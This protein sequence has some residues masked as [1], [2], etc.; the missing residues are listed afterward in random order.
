MRYRVLEPRRAPPLALVPP[1]EREPESGVVD[2]AMSD[3]SLVVATRAGDRVARETLFR[4]HAPAAFGLA[5]RLL[6]RADGEVDDLVQESLL[7]CVRGLDRLETPAAFGSW[8]S[9]I[10]V[11]TACKVIRRRTIATRLGLRR[12]GPVVDLD[13]LV[14]H[15]APPDVR[16]ELRAVFRCLE[17]LPARERV[18][19]VLRRVD[20]AS[21][22]EIAELMDTSPRSAKRWVESAEDELVIELERGAT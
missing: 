8:L 14:S 15:D 16:A 7:A 6:G 11:R 3:A 1:P 19:L 5:R 13:A 20:G 18:A 21:Y 10:V 17:R 2:S 12:S 22:D 9:G 4:R